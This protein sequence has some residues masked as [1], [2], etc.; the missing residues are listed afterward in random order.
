MAGEVIDVVV[1]QDVLPQRAGAAIFLVATVEDGAESDVRQLLADLSG[2]TRSVGFRLPD[3]D[4]SCV[5]GIGAA[6]WD[7]LFAGPRPASLHPFHEIAGARHVAVSTPGDLLF[8]LRAHQIDVCFELARQLTLRLGGRAQIVDEVHG[9]TYFDQRDLMGFVDG[10]ENPTGVA[11]EAAAFIDESDP[12]F[13]GGSYVIVQK[14]LHDLDAWDALPVEQQERVVGRTKL[15]DIEMS[16]ETKPSNSHVALNTIVGDDGVER[17]IVRENMAFGR[18]GAGEFGTYFIGYAAD[19]GVT[20][21]MLHNMFIGKPVG[22]YDRILD[23]S[24]AV[25]GALFFVP[26]IDFL[27]DLPGMPTTALPEA[28]SASDDDVQS[29]DRSLRIGSLKGTA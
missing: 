6:L 5:V 7:R 1:S 13:A 17:Q 22:N 24:T 12:D 29:L 9:F 10:T 25:T 14:Y 28:R 19:P 27:D 23:F 15:S 8:H 3:R 16:D 20:E 11:A 18:L 26:S 2:L 21:L 4:L